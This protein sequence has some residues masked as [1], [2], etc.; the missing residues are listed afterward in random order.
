M[1]IATTN[2]GKIAELAKGFRGSFKEVPGATDA[3]TNSPVSL[4]IVVRETSVASLINPTSTPGIM[5]PPWS[6]IVPRRPP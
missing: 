5:A 4:V 2:P 1:V 3:N 6:R